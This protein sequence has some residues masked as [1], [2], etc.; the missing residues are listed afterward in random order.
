M[1]L[2]DSHRSPAIFFVSDHD[3]GN[4]NASVLGKRVFRAANNT[5]SSVF[6]PDKPCPSGTGQCVVLS[7]QRSTEGSRPFERLS[8]A[9]H[10]TARSQAPRRVINGGST[11]PGAYANINSCPLS[12]KLQ[13][14]K[15]RRSVR[16]AVR[17]PL[18]CSCALKFLRPGKTNG[19]ILYVIRQR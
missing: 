5:I 2:G 11:V 6:L 3:P 15:R 10:E 1:I 18:P 16:T 4:E 12:G 14:R 17:F 9:R 8:G 7:A 19:G 13:H